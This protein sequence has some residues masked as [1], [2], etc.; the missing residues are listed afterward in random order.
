MVK[1]FDIANILLG[2][3]SAKSNVSHIPWVHPK[4][5]WNEE[6]FV[7]HDHSRVTQI[8]ELKHAQDLE[9]QTTGVEGDAQDK[10]G[11]TNAR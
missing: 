9:S 2:H 7:G 4:S 11:A 1:K 10:L 5:L 8:G 3:D 6:R